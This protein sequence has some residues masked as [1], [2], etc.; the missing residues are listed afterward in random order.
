VLFILHDIDNQTNSASHKEQD[1][2]A[3]DIN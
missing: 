1:T 2:T 3:K